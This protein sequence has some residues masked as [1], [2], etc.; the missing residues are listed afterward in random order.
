MRTK[1]PREKFPLMLN[2]FR[3]KVRTY[4]LKQKNIDSNSY[5]DP[6]VQ[7]LGWRNVRVGQNS[8]ISEQTWINVN[9]RGRN[10]ISIIIGNNCFIGRRNFLSSGE[11]IRIGDFCLTGPNC[12]FLG[13]NQIYD[14]PFFP[15]LTTG[16]TQV[17][18]IELGPNC[19]LGA[20]VTLLN[21]IK[22]G[23]GSIIGAATVVNR[24]IPPLSVVV[25]NPC[26][27]IKRFDMQS[28]SWVSAEEYSDENDQDLMSEAEYIE[29][30]KKTE[31]S[32]EKVW[33]ASSKIFG[34]L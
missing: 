6:S 9:H 32:L 10:N 29:I 5:V 33:I 30:L 14:S 28:Q 25:G 18:V 16:T 21:N 23:Y 2:R 20:N 15:Y 24:D 3:N 31:F 4:C 8:V 26:R 34:D 7:V 22:I 12:N 13:S 17:G 19:W 11:L 27:I 1:E